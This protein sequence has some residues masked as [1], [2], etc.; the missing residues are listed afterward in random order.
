MKRIFVLFLVVVMLVSSLALSSCDI[1]K[2]KLGLGTDG[3]VYRLN[4]DGETC[5]V[6]GL[7]NCMEDDIIIPKTYKGKTVTGIAD[8]AFDGQSGVKSITIPNTVTDIG[9]DVFFGAEN[10][11]DIYF[12]H[13]L[14]ELKNNNN[15]TE[16]ETSNKKDDNRRINIYVDGELYFSY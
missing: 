4:P 1:I 2:K 15:K 11:T 13:T 8:K 6:I 9:E 3:L 16:E 10:L 5:T 7:H 12:C 14:E